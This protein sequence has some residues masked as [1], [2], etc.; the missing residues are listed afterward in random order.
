MTNNA[1]FTFSVDDTHTHGLRLVSSKPHLCEG[2][3]IGHITKLIDLLTVFF[4]D[5]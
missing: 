1:R 2:K 5:V 4:G 3:S